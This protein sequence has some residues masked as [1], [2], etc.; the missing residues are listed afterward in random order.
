MYSVFSCWN[1]G[2]ITRDQENPTLKNIEWLSEEAEGY[3]PMTCTA[4]KPQKSWGTIM[5]L[6]SLPPKK[7][8]CIMQIP[9]LDLFYL[10]FLPLVLIHKFRLSLT[11]CCHKGIRIAILAGKGTGNSSKSGSKLH[12][13][14]IVWAKGPAN[15]SGGL[16]LQMTTEGIPQCFVSLDQ[17]EF[18][19]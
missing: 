5:Y 16:F 10:V 15:R 12:P 18:P 1:A 11:C 7:H 6:E 8:P 9:W 19:K 4:Y 14:G 2:S 3:E 17:W 13:S